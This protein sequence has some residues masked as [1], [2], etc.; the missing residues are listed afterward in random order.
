MKRKAAPAPRPTRKPRRKPRAAAPQA[1]GDVDPLAGSALR[2]LLERYCKLAGVKQ[3]ALGPDHTELK[4]PPAERPF[5]RDRERVSV[6]FSLDALE[7]EP[8][9]VAPADP[10]AVAAPPVPAREP[11]ELLQLLVSHLR[12][13]AGERVATRRAA[14]EQELAAE[15][16]RLDRYFESV[17]KEQADA[18][19]I[20]T[21]SALAERR[22][23]EE[24]RRSQVKAVVHP[25]Q[26]V[27]AAV[28]MQR[29]EWRLESGRGRRATFAAQRSLSGGSGWALTCPPCGRPPAALVNLRADPC[30][31]EAC[32]HPLPVG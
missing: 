23:A 31:F 10:A 5:F 29:A 14:A 30:G 15:L 1:P 4:L 16:G 3:A 9:R 27:A 13:R 19:A 18:E 6:A 20:A 8:G 32:S 2:P 28:L 24:I 26:L 22:R 12:A 7:R 25:L 21:V 11:G 17:L